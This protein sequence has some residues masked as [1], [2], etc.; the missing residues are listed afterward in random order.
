MSCRKKK[1]KTG[2]LP[3]S[4]F[5][6]FRAGS[7]RRRKPARSSPARSSPSCG[8][9]SRLIGPAHR[10]VTVGFCIQIKQLWFAGEWAYKERHRGRNQ[11]EN[12]YHLAWQT[13][14]PSIDGQGAESQ[15]PQRKTSIY[16]Q[17]CFCL[18]FVPMLPR[19]PL[20]QNQRILAS[21]PLKRSSASSSPVPN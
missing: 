8:H 9:S 15:G 18:S 14:W 5:L 20:A 10:H 19:S 4:G 16:N 12:L 1:V 21:R 3:E 7:A 6:P 13:G 2:R 11:L 17:Y